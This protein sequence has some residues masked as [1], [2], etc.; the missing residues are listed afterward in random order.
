ME[1]NHGAQKEETGDTSDT[2]LVSAVLMSSV[3]SFLCVCPMFRLCS[4]L[5]RML[6]L[7]IIKALIKY[8]NKNNINK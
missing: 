5:L 4:F 1:T 7:K 8:I 2:A 3:S 6:W